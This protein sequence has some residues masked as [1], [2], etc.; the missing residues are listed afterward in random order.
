MG[1]VSN[2]K[3]ELINNVI[4]KSCN[5][6]NLMKPLEDFKPTSNGIMMR[7]PSCRE[8]ENKKHK[9]RRIDN[10]EKVREAQ[11]KSTYGIS[12]EDYKKLY[13]EQNG[14]CKICNIFVEVLDVDHCHFTNIVRG[15]LCHNCNVA[16]GHLKDN[17]LLL[18]RAADYLL[19]TYKKDN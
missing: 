17:P 11:L 4:C 14:C 5:I 6:C 18:L 1:C 16:I 8:C 15:L 9:Q 12:N 19:D 7:H 10:P 2:S 3:V 13:T